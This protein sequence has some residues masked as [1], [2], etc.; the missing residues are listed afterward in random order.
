MYVHT[1]ADALVQHYF[2]SSCG[3]TLTFVVLGAVA[4]SELPYYCFAKRAELRPVIW[5]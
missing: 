5:W 1:F 4:P 3:F 2:F